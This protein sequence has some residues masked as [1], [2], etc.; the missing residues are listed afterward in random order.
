MIVVLGMPVDC[1]ERSTGDTCFWCGGRYKDKEI[2]IDVGHGEGS[3][4]MKVGRIHTD[5]YNILFNG[6][7]FMR[8][9]E[10]A[11]G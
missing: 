2:S 7:G 6:G 9:V 3:Y 10:V 8:L 4:E 11:N 5:C 1:P